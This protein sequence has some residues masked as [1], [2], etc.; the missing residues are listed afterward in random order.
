MTE[1]NIAPVTWL[2][3]GGHLAAQLTAREGGEGCGQGRSH[4]AGCHLAGGS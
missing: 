2:Q 4:L 3:G 1:A